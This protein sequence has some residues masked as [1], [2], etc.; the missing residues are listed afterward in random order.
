MATL[1]AFAEEPAQRSAKVM[2]SMDVIQTVSLIVVISIVVVI[3]AV[4][5]A[6]MVLKKMHIPPKEHDEEQNKEE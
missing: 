2:L 3:L 5:I 6:K 4:H 1:T